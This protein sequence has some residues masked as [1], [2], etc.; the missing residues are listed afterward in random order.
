M[1]NRVCTTI[2]RARQVRLSGFKS[3]R[4]THSWTP[5]EP[6][7]VKY[8]YIEDVERLDFYVPGGYHP[9]MIGDQLCNG[10]YVIA[11][12]LG[13]GRS[14]TAWLAQDTKTSQ[15]VCLKISTAESANRTN[16][17]PILLQLGNA[18][19]QLPGKPIVQML[20][21]QFTFSGP[22][23]FHQCLVSDA[24]R[25]SIHEAKDASYHRILHL[26]AARAIA[27]QLVLGLQFIHFQ[28]IVHGD[29]HLGN[30]FLQLPP[31][32]QTMTPEQLYA[33]TGGPFKELVVRCDGAPL[34]PGVPPEVV[35]PVWLGS[36]SDEI[37]LADC[38]IQIA[39]LGEAFDP[40]VTKQFNAHT[41]PQLAPPEA[42]FIEPGEDEPLS[43]SGDMWSLA[44]T[45]WE[46]FGAG[47]PF[48]P[49]PFTAD[50]VLIEHAEMLGR[51]PDRWW[52]KWKSR[53]NWFNDDGTKN[54][55]EHLQQQFGNSSDNWDKRFPDYIYSYRLRSKFPVFTPEEEEAFGAMIKS[56][57]VLEPSKRATIDDVVKCEWMQKWGLP[58]L[59][60]MRDAMKQ[61]TSV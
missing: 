11:H 58:E 6:S 45:I 9:V 39:D 27:S 31:N 5:M 18:E 17:L 10:R 42:F 59:Q 51:F 37:T 28:G 52:S 25:I 16:E 14:A 24:A 55:K 54:V 40:Q 13:S 4:R 23:G 12:K 26:P 22:N 60:R 50:G 53:S 44:C 38:S 7:K 20:L 47:P 56:M 30:V 19:S 33:K 49:F 57:L 36:A 34:D 35:I 48:L 46:V 32:M 1:S 2:L 21:D 3:C 43:F 41:L 15:L 29:I 61:V 8:K